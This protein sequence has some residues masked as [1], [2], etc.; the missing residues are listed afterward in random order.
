MSVEGMIAYLFQ[1]LLL[2]MFESTRSDDDI[3]TEI[4]LP[5]I[6]STPLALFPVDGTSEPWI[7]IAF[8]TEPSLEE[9]ANA[10]NV[11]I[12]V[13][14]SRTPFSIWGPST[15]KSR[16]EIATRHAPFRICVRGANHLREVD[17]D[18]FSRGPTD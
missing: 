18:R 15:R 1:Q 11:T 9:R 14:T 3:E 5:T 8:I 2:G 13:P 4:F 10:L 6:F 17:N 7:Q 16:P 12:E